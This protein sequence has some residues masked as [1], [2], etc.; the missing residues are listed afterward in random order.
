M[1]QCVIIKIANVEQ[2]TGGVNIYIYMDVCQFIPAKN[3]R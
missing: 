3:R 1:I 2:I